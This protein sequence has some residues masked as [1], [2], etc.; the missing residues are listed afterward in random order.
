[1]SG[2][3]TEDPITLAMRDFWHAVAFAANLRDQPLAARLLGEDLVLFR[4]ADGLVALRDRCLHRGARLSLGRVENGCIECPYHGWRYDAQGACV[5]VPAR[6]ELVGL[7]KATIPRYKVTEAAGLLW[8]CLGE[9]RL[10]PP[11]FP[12]LDDPDYRVIPGHVYDWKTSAPRRLENFCDFGHFAFV[13][14][15]SLGSRERPRVEPVKLWREE[16]VLRVTR[17]GIGEPSV[18]RKKMLLGITEEFIEP[19]NEYHIHMPCTVHLK[20]IFPNGK[21]YVLF[22][23][24]SPVEAGITRSFWWQARDFGMEA[25]HD[26]F[27]LDFERQ[28]LEEDLPIIESQRPVAIPLFGLERRGEVSLLPGDQISVEYRKWLTELCQEADRASRHAAQQ[29]SPETTVP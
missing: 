4:T 22:M 10:P 3:S 29:M 21:C 20:R 24:A 1:M 14:H 23:S 13:H 18:G 6:E 7:V 15:G 11:S 9:P 27:F 17:G 2:E 5:R 12:E 26:E 25:E 16:G 28:V 19:V 8:V